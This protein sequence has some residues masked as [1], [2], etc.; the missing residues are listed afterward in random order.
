[1]QKMAGQ[2]LIRPGGRSER[3]QIAVHQAVRD[4]QAEGASEITVPMVAAKAEV[5]P[6]TIYRRWQTIEGLLA[7]VA[8]NDLLGDAELADTGSLEG[9]LAI[10]L[11]NFVED[12]STGVGRGLLRERVFN[13]TIA[14]VTAGYA[15]ENFETLVGRAEARG[16]QA[17]TPDWLMDLLVAPVLYRML[18]MGQ[19]VTKGYERELVARAVNP[20]A[21][22][23]SK[24]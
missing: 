20:Q 17:P 9:D 10:W 24:A 8:A 23:S 16:E 12:M 5:T 19:I 7:A 2:P 21:T 3:I 6:S 22:S 15:F 14:R 11:A 13:V 1:M 4:L 18:F